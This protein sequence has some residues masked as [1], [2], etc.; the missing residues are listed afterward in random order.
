M[1]L[2]TYFQT[3]DMTQAELARR[4]GVTPSFVSQLIN[5]HRPIPAEL[6]IPIEEAT[7]GEVPRHESRADIYPPDEY[8]AA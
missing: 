7:E 8:R 4:I 6:A 5:K 3:H 1:D 2:K